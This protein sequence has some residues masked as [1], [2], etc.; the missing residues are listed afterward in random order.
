MNHS[1]K[2]K[3]SQ[4]KLILLNLVDKNIKIFIIIMFKEIRKKYAYNFK[5]ENCSRVNST[6]ETS[7]S[8]RSKIE[9]EKW[10]LLEELK[11][12]LDTKEEM[13]NEFENRAIEII[14]TGK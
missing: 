3:C 2:K 7:Q 13:P 1:K 14:Q 11:N 10:K 12:I 6:K 4:K 9:T 5:S 8:S